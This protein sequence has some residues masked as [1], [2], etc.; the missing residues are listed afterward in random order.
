[1]SRRGIIE[2]TRPAICEFCGEK[3]EL[4]PYGPNGENICF[5]CGMKDEKMTRRRFAQHIFG[6]DFDA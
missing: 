5:E 2:K 1:M 3:Q 4:R 6:E